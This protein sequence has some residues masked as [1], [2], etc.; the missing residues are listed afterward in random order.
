[1]IVYTVYIGTGGAFNEAAIVVFGA[2]PDVCG[3]VVEE[4]GVG[5]AGQ[6]DEEAAD[7]GGHQEDVCGSVEH[8]CWPG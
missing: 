6:C 5:C 1:M 7:C 4:Q 8:D 2:L 3:N